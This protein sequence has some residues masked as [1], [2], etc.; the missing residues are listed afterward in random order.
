VEIAIVDRVLSCLFY[1]E[2][3]FLFVRVHIEFI[4]GVHDGEL[5]GDL[6]SDVC[7]A[8]LRIIEHLLRHIGQLVVVRVY[9]AADF[10]RDLGV[11]DKPN[12]QILQWY[13]NIVPLLRLLNRLNRAHNS[14]LAHKMIQQGA[15]LAP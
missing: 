8:G 1:V 2:V 3:S 13:G 12:R 14:F 4:S 7:V 5:V 10:S 15:I 9:R 6:L 11:S